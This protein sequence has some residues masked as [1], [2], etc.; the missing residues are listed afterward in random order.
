MVDVNAPVTVFS[1]LD[2]T[3]LPPKC[4]RGITFMKRRRHFAQRPSQLEFS[5]SPF[6]E[7]DRYLTPDPTA[8]GGHKQ[9]KEEFPGGPRIHGRKHFD[10]EK[11]AYQ[12]DEMGKYIM[13]RGAKGVLFGTNN[14]GERRRGT[15]HFAYYHN[16]KTDRVISHEQPTQ[17]N[18]L[19]RKSFIFI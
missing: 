19:L 2:V 5:N 14:D 4:A 11:N 18:D 17:I 8:F 3:N 12:D 9:Y 1:S 13:N 16:Q 6:T 7:R 10:N 15:K